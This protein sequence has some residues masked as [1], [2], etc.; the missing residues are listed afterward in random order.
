MEKNLDLTWED[1]QFLEE[2]DK[3]HDPMLWPYK[4]VTKVQ[5]LPPKV[6]LY[7]T[8]FFG[9]WIWQDPEDDRFYCQQVRRTA[10]KK[11][12]KKLKKVLDKSQVLWYYNYRKR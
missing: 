7:G 10:L 9:R 1:L 2:Y 4:T 3:A 5:T 8:D 12:L 11:F 6:I